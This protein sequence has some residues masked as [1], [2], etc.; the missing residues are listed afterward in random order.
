M[1][2]VF[3][4]IIVSKIKN[5]DFKGLLILVELKPHLAY[6]ENDCTKIYQQ[7]IQR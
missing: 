5:K 7:S 4:H 2:W 3:D 1:I 6:F